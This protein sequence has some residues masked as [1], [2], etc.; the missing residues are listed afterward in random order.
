MGFTLKPPDF[1]SS[2]IDKLLQIC[3][4]LANGTAYN[5]GFLDHELPLYNRYLMEFIGICWLIKV[6]TI[7]LC[8]NKVAG[9]CANGEM[10][11]SPASIIRL[12]SSINI[13]CIL[14]ES[15]CN[16]CTAQQLCIIEDNT[17]RLSTV[18]IST[19]AVTAHIPK[20]ENPKSSF[21]CKLQCNT[22]YLICGI[23]IE[24]GN[25]P[26]Q[27]RD[28]KCIQNGRDG[29]VTCSWDVGQVTHI[30]TNHVL[31]F[32]NESHSFIASAASAEPSTGKCT[33]QRRTQEHQKLGFACE[34]GHSFNPY[35]VYSAWITALNQLG[36]QSSAFMN[37][38]LDEIVKPN[39][40]NISKV[41]FSSGSPIISTIYWKDQQ[42]TEW[43]EIRCRS[44]NSRWEKKFFT[45]STSC[46]VY[47]LEH[48]TE[49]DF[50]V[51][52]KFHHTHG[53][54]S[55]WST[56]FVSKTPE[57]APIGQLDVWYTMDLSDPNGPRVT[58]LWKLLNVPESRG[59][60]LGYI[61]T[62]QKSTEKNT[63]I[64]TKQTMNT[65]Y[66]VGIPRTGYTITV[67]AYNS[68]GNSPPT[69]LLIPCFTD[70][71][72]PRNIAAMY[73]GNNRFKIEWTEPVKQPAPVQGYVVEWTE[74]NDK[75]NLNINW[76][77]LPPQNCSA[78]L[79]ENIKPK[80]CFRISVYAIYES[81][82]GRPLSTQR[83]SAQEAAP[84][85]GP[86]AF[87][88]HN[89]AV[90]FWKNAPQDQQVGCI[91]SYTIYLQ[92]ENSKLPP[93][94]YRLIDPT[95]R[96]YTIP[97]LKPGTGYIVWMTAVTRAGEGKHGEQHRFYFK[98]GSVL[99]HSDS[100]SI[101]MVVVAV[102]FLV[103]VTVSGFCLWQSVR[104]RIWSILSKLT[105]R[106]YVSNI[107]D[108][109]NCTWAKEYTAIK[110]KMDLTY[111]GFQSEST[112]TYEDPETLQVE[113]IS[114]QEFCSSMEI[115]DQDQSSRLSVLLIQSRAHPL[116][117][118]K[119]LSQG[120]LSPGN[121]QEH[122]LDYKCQ[123]PCLYIEKL[124]SVEINQEL[125][126]SNN[127]I[128]DQNVGYIP[129]NFLHVTDNTTETNSDIFEDSF[130]FMPLPSLSKMAIPYGGKLTLDV[131]KI[132]CSSLVE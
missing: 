19:N 44:T 61:V 100:K 57:A 32:R 117:Q 4:Q 22:E 26:D 59:R 41:E 64:W 9:S 14:K 12:G 74:V 21:A 58:L 111:T 88:K 87:T 130:S 76:I 89:N 70:L 30:S 15:P 24:A 53:L 54:W 86:R 16:G 82:A 17:K 36:N 103:A 114:E 52:C 25:P 122:I 95:S 90:I 127:S 116:Q 13:S 92:E 105:S 79:A 69:Q 11:V 104:N 1:R 49:Y 65:W 34:S 125:T 109:A 108:P 123:L 66:T 121:S 10:R 5:L 60:I 20:F 83:Y 71:P 118:S 35:S 72:P 106:L 110:G 55:D 67:S 91:E 8:K 128:M 102:T 37:F 38:T 27:P 93:T 84:L 73:A 29:D 47:D 94:I 28:L 51:R 132:D 6:I 31:W 3:E 101:I 33:R 99:P 62:L 119:E 97:D 129:S 126:N 80:T 18:Q 75:V 78:T 115:V 96:N 50:Q 107:P 39:P 63:T 77:K 23:D 46:K 131:V 98:Q 42:N 120:G 112:S 7:L 81:G 85:S 2:P 45:N 124:P 113:E 48:F 68:K 56:S 43:L 40:P